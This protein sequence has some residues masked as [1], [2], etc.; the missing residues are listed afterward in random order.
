[1]ESPAALLIPVAAAETGASASGKMTDAAPEGSPEASLFLGNPPARASLE[2]HGAALQPSEAAQGGLSIIR[3]RTVA[4]S[5]VLPQLETDKLSRP[6]L[7]KGQ[8][9]W[10]GFVA[11]GYS[12]D[13]GIHPIRL[14]LE[15]LPPDK[16][17]AEE[18]FHS[19]GALALNVARRAFP[20]E[21][22]SVPPAKTPLR[23]EN[24]LT[25]HTNRLGEAKKE[26][27]SRALWEGAFIRPTEGRISSEFG[28]IREADGV[29]TSRHS[30]IDLAN[31][32][33]TP[34]R[35]A[36]SGRV[37]LSEYMTVTGHSVIIDHGLNLYTAYYHMQEREV[38]AG[39][40]VKKGQHVGLMGST[41]YSTGPH[42]HWSATIG[43]TPIDPDIL[44]KGD[45]LSLSAGG[46]G[47]S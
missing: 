20:V 37:V 5:E 35:A 26:T 4:G 43:G 8:E 3:F 18:G 1:M 28:L 23:S 32:E 30:G 16:P 15:R 47:S 38:Q 22:I 6:L 24:N 7:F 12:L 39:D 19:A 40:E 25:Q 27:S 17:A 33:G 46:S 44:T 42:L 9:G 13:P 41:G 31:R 45:P 34:I 14:S 29:P 11:A 2:I 36:N 10:S 21:R